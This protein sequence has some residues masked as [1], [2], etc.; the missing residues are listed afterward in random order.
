MEPQR[1][2]WKQE[3]GSDGVL[4][5]TERGAEF[6]V[7]IVI[8][9]GT[10][11]IYYATGQFERFRVFLSQVPADLPIFICASD[12]NCPSENNNSP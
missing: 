5:T 11:E 7:T 1:R 8:T 12:L 9:Y 6:K 10:E 2:V 3:A 4:M